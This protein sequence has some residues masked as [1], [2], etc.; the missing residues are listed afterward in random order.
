MTE[1]PNNNDAVYVEESF[2]SLSVTV[3]TL[4]L[5]NQEL[6]KTV[7]TMKTEIAALKNQTSI[8]SKKISTMPDKTPTTAKLI[9]GLI[10]Q[11][12]KMAEETRPQPRRPGSLLTNAVQIY[13]LS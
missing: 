2:T 3:E 7:A 10:V 13:P 5:E 11:P 6:T 9:E 4:I 12:A 8:L 1:A